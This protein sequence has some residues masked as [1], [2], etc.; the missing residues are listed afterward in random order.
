MIKLRMMM[1]ASRTV[2]NARVSDAFNE[3]QNS[4]IS[5]RLLRFASPND[6]ESRHFIY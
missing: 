4:K 3:L 1:T 5:A 6:P 2:Q